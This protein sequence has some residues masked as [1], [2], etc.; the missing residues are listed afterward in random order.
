M[1]TVG[2]EELRAVEEHE[3]VQSYMSQ[4]NRDNV[5]FLNQLWCLA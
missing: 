4:N 5:R 1:I 2:G 3:V